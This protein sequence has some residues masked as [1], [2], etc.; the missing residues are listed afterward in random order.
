MLLSWCPKIGRVRAYIRL[1]DDTLC[2]LAPYPPTIGG[3]EP[4]VGILVGTRV[5]PFDG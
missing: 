2:A 1:G 5:E 4:K 3:I